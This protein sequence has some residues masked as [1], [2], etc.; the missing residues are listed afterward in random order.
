MGDNHANRARGGRSTAREATADTTDTSEIKPSRGRTQTVVAALAEY[1]TIT[2]GTEAGSVV[3]VRRC[4]E[5]E[6]DLSGGD[7]HRV[8]L[9]GATPGM[10][11]RRSGRIN[12]HCPVR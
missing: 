7:A 5:A 9:V 6:Y 8:R 10:P 4:F 2:Q 1:E 12:R 3:S 11:S